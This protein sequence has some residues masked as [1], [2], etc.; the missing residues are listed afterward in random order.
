MFKR[1]LFTNLLLLTGC[2]I[3][4]EPTSSKPL[5]D[6]DDFKDRQVLFSDTFL[7]DEPDYMLYI[8]SL[9]CGHCKEIKQDVLNYVND[10][11]YPIYLSQFTSDIVVGNDIEETIGVSSTDDLFIAGTPT[12]IHIIDKKVYANIPGTSSILSYLSLQLEN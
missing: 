3:T 9:T 6:Y 4:Q 7:I 10:V 2:S 12:L 1:L 8:Y 5:L 11:D